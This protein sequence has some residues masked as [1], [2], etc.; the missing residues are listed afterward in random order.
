LSASYH[1]TRPVGTGLTRLS[2][3][4]DYIRKASRLRRD[5]FR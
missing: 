4:N 3:T 1:L 5:A 2:L